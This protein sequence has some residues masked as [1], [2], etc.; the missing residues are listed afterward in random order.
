MV[1]VGT[2]PEI[3]RLSAVIKKLEQF[4]QVIL[5]HTGQNYDYNLNEVFFQ[6]LELRAPDYH[7]EV[8]NET[9]GQAVGEIIAKSYTLMSKEQPDALLILGDTNS[10]LSA[11]SAKRLKIPV[12]HMEAGNRCFDFNVPEEINRRVVDHVSDINLTYSENARN[13][14]IAEGKKDDTVY[15]TGS[16]MTEVLAQFETKIKASNICERLKIKKGQYF[17]VSLH[18]EENLDVKDNFKTVCAAINTVAEK[19]QLPI[20]FS[21]HPRTRKKIDKEHIKFGPLVQNLEPLGFLDYNAL[22]LNAFCVLSDSGTITEESSIMHFPAVSVRNSQERPEGLDA[23]TIILS[24]INS[25]DLISAIEIATKTHD[26]AKQQT[27]SDYTA[28][29][30]SDKILRLITSYTNI[31]NQRTW[32]K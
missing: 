17:V 2:R 3:I 32:K 9:A 7:L 1:V 20:I 8:K 4:H 26:T 25:A 23:G 6:D 21:T 10:C 31:V 24:G 14:L 5:V 29:N 12:F 22:Q 13:Y 27:V 18:R 16:P 19:Y 28:T 15:V 30:V 11:Y